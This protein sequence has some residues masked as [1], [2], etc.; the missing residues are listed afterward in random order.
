M[1]YFHG[2][3][4]ILTRETLSIT[5]LK[6]M[7]TMFGLMAANIKGPGTTTKWKEVESIPGLMVVDM[8]V[9]TS[10]IRRRARVHFVGPMDVSM[11]ADG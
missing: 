5:K 2:L 9:I 1:D 10:M 3:I 6:D 4:E 11:K 7:V 8:K